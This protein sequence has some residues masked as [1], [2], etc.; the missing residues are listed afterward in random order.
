MEVVA[1][2]T[3]QLRSSD[4]YEAITVRIVLFS[5][6]QYIHPESIYQ[7]LREVRAGRVGT[8]STTVP[9]AI[10]PRA[11]R[12][13]VVRCCPG[14]HPVRPV[15]LFPALRVDREDRTSNRSLISHWIRSALGRMIT[16]S[17][18]VLW[19]NSCPSP[20]KNIILW[21]DHIRDYNVGDD[22]YF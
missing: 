10:L 17:Q 9:P 21:S 20:S 6:V 5:D 2:I 14:I 4:P 12:I 18:Y 22:T 7:A 11:H 3:E 8:G 13:P 15:R 16:I 1:Q 19:P